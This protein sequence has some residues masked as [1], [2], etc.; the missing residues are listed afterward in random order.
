MPCS[1]LQQSGPRYVEV[2]KEGAVVLVPVRVNSNLKTMNVEEILRQ[3]KQMHVAAFRNLVCDEL[4]HDL[5]RIAE[6]GNATVRYEVDLC[7]EHGGKVYTVEDLIKAI[8]DDVRKTFRR[9]EH[10]DHERY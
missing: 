6:E 2:T 7:K 3:K 1:F 10:L 8:A 4:P 5:H 9:H